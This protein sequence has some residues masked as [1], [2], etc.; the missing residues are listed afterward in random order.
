MATATWNGTL[1]ASSPD[2]VELDGYTYFPLSSVTPGVLKHSATT[3]VCTFK[4]TA[5][6]YTLE[7]G[8]VLNPDAGW[9]YLDPSQAAGQ[10]AGRVAFWKGT[11]I[12]P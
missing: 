4:G 12:T 5:T 6:Y 11:V 9:S 8:G 1:I 10:I 2:V 3:S 7:V